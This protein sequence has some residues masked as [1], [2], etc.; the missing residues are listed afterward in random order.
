MRIYTFL[1][2]FILCSCGAYK[3]PPQSPACRCDMDADGD[4][5]WNCT[6]RCGDTPYGI[7][8][9]M[10]GCPK[11]TDGDGVADYKDKQLIT[12]TEC[13][14][15]DANGI[16]ECPCPCTGKIFQ[17]IICCS[18]TPEFIGFSHLSYD[19]KDDG[20]KAIENFVKQMRSNPSCVV[21]IVGYAGNTE[22]E[23]TN[24]ALQA[25]WSRADVVKKILV[26]DFNIDAG[27]IDIRIGRIGFPYLV[28]LKGFENERSN[29]NPP[30]PFQNLIDKR[31]KRINY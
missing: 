10:H 22:Q 11:D 7:A 30:A 18:F 1:I 24:A 6:D 21:T 9:D 28:E 17:G 4:G 25:S 3:G 16:G 27:R 19:I 8:V 13:Q 23:R 31:N 5:I 29:P 26:H 20:M 14:P 12:P 15:S 2:L